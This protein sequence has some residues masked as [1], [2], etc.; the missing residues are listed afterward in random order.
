MKNI[1]AMEGDAWD[2]AQYHAHMLPEVGIEG[3]L[4]TLRI[5]TVDAPHQPAIEAKIGLSIDE[6]V[7]NESIRLLQHPF[8]V[9][10]EKDKEELIAALKGALER[11][12][13]LRL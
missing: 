8:R 5:K 7:R 12:S 11:I 6:L 1:I 2:V 13:S 9:E 10:A 4:V 3:G